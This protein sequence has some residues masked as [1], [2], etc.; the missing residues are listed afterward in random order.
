MGVFSYGGGGIPHPDAPQP[1]CEL[2]KPNIND[3]LEKE[4]LSLHQS[5]PEIQGRGEGGGG[6]RGKVERGERVGG[7][8]GE[9]GRRERREVGS[10]R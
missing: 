6:G 5:F 9:S 2:I 7:G 1:L 10:G 3:S 8:R 4:N